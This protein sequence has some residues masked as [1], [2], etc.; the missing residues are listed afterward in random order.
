MKSTTTAGAV[1]VTPSGQRKEL[2]VKDV[3]KRLRN[4]NPEAEV[5]VIVH[6][7]VEDFTISWGGDMD[8]EGTSK[9]QTTGV[10]FYVDRLC[11][12]ENQ[13]TLQHSGTAEAKYM[14]ARTD[15]ERAADAK[16]KS[17]TTATTFSYTPP[18]SRAARKEVAAMLRIHAIDLGI[19][20]NHCEDAGLTIEYEQDLRKRIEKLGQV[21]DWI[22]KGLNE[23]GK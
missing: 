5:G 22:E 10:H 14:D 11:Q 15:R 9:S 2:R 16:I 19:E 7:K 1:G 23:E 4:F 17:T 18:P 6:N 12:N 20:A 3:I 13:P 8:R 21:A